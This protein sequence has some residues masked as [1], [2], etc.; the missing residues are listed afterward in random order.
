MNFNAAVFSDLKC[1]SFGAIIRNVAGE[2]M[3]GMSIMGPY[4]NNSEEGEVLACRK[5]IEFS[6]EAGFLELVIKGD[7]V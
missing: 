2:V 1:S 7:N 3:A 5:A 6:F 4:V